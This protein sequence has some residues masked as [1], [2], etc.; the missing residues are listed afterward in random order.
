M[1]TTDI[2]FLQDLTG[3]YFDDLPRLKTLLPAV[4]NRLTNPNLS[5]IFGSNLQFGLRSFKDKP[6]SPFGGFGDYVYKK[7]VS[8]TTNAALVKTAVNGFS[9][10][11]GGDLPESQLEALLQAA[12]DSTIGYRVGSKRIVVLATDAA[13]HVAGDGLTLAPGTITVPNN[14]DGIISANEDYPGILQVKNALIANN[15]IP[16]FLATSDVK[17]SYDALVGSLGRGF[18]TTLDSNSENVADGIKFAVAKASGTISPGGEGTDGDNII[19]GSTVGTTGDKVV[20]SG[21]GNDEVNLSAVSGNHFIDGGAGFDT[22]FGG[23]GQ[24]KIDAGSGNDELIGGSGNDILLGSSGDDTILGGSGN[25]TI[26]G[27]SGDDLLTGGLGNDRFVFDTGS[28]FTAADLGIDTIN[29]FRRVAGN[30]DK[31][32]LSRDTFNLL[33]IGPTL[34]SLDFASVATDAL[35]E[36]STAKIV[37]STGTRSLFYNTNGTTSGFGSGGQFAL[38]GVSTPTL[39]AS[40]FV[41]VD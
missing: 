30:T 38:F 3:S 11:G 41:I 8:L 10:S 22:L 17:S 24:D 5:L 21:G 25:D 20:F 33:P 27:D 18:V 19:N 29:D 37:Y 39:I 32:E 2:V 16:V 13:Y 35:A 12:L 4:V 28:P 34:S 23:I 36:I 14:G 15:I 7:E 6:V 26:Q 9:A 40:D 31:I 1:A